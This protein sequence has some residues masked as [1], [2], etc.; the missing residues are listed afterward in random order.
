[1]A[2][3]LTTGARGMPVFSGAPERGIGLAYMA[4]PTGGYLAGY[5]LGA[6][7][8]GWLAVG[9]RANRAFSGC[10][11]RPRGGLCARPHLARQ[12]REGING[13]LGRFH[14]VYSW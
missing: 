3:C 14:A 11:R 2:T 9:S 8:T 12:I 13:G 4:G 10:A 6:G 5:L 1:M 7:L